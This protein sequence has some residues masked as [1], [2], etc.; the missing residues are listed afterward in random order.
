M[1]ME[2]MLDIRAS[3]QFQLSISKPWIV[4]SISSVHFKALDSIFGI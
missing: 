4:S 2:W 3:A 1:V